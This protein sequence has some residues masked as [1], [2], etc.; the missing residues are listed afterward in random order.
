MM[1][2]ALEWALHLDTKLGALAAAHGAWVYLIMFGVIFVET[3]VVVMPFLPGDSLLFVAG[4]LAAAGALHPWALFG[5]ALAAAIAGDTANFWVGGKLR[6]RVEAGKPLRFL[7]QEHLDRTDAFFERHGPKAVVLARF[8]PV[9]RTLAP[10]VAALGSMNYRRFIAY[11]VIGGLLWVTA[12]VGVGYAFGNVQWI[13]DH[14]SAVLLG[15][16]AVSILPAII[17]WA[18]DRKSRADYET[19]EP[20]RRR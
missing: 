9:V 18:K 13:R 1:Q 3:G 8:V 19:D 7:N 12:L 15:I 6:E 11:N 17:G 10:F 16:V 5:A 14:L 4:A 2:T 20:A